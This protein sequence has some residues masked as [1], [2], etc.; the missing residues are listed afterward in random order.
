MRRAEAMSSRETRGSP[1]HRVA[2]ASRRMEDDSGVQ[3]VGNVIA[4]L[5]LLR[6]TRSGGAATC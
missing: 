2:A 6:Q 3:Q 5:R 1:G 4:K